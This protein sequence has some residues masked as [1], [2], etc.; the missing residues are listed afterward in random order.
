ML[1]RSVAAKVTHT[2]T[3]TH[4]HTL[5]PWGLGG[6]LEGT[7]AIPGLQCLLLP[8][9]E[10]RPSFP[11]H[12][13]EWSGVLKPETAG[14]AGRPWPQG[15]GLE[16]SVVLHHAGPRLQSCCASAPGAR[17]RLGRCPS[18]Q[19]CAWSWG[20]GV[21]VCMGRLH[22]PPFTPKVLGEPGRSCRLRTTPTPERRAWH[23]PPS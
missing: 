11:A 7:D 6:G 12:R 4:T 14:G 3:H 5:Q 10:C 2:H 1:F 8:G 22:C 23:P 13:G 9:S 20:W 18:L 21:G 16:A 19:M 17:P 15:V